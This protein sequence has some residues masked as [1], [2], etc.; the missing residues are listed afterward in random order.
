MAVAAPPLD[1]EALA[2][3]GIDLDTVRRAAER[4]SA[5]VA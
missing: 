1:A 5:P 3:I 2:A 4:R